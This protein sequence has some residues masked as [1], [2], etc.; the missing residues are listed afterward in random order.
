VYAFHSA[1]EPAPRRTPPGTT[2]LAVLLLWRDPVVAGR[3]A[4]LVVTRRAALRA[5]P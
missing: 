3:L 1:W 4:A 2:F 5:E